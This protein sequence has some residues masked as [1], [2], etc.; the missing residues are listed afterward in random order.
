MAKGKEIKYMHML[1]P[2]SMQQKA[3]NFYNAASA[4]AAPAA[5][6]HASSFVF[7][8][9]KLELRLETSSPTQTRLGINLI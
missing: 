8:L 5:L 2:E 6:P 9:R 1:W 7:K 4:A 3:F